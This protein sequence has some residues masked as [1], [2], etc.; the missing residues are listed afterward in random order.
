MI[1]KR[2]RP[3]KSLPR[4][5]VRRRRPA[6]G[7]QRPVVRR[8]SRR[9]VQPPRTGWRPSVRI[10]RGWLKPLG[11][12]AAVFAVLAAAVVTWQSPLFQV[13]HLE[14]R[15]NSRVATESIV[16]RAAL[17]GE[18]MFTADLATSQKAIYGLP[19]VHAV[20]I[21]RHWPNR[22]TIT[23]EERQAWG[24]WEQGG[25][26]YTIDRDGVVLGSLPAAE[27][28][29]VILSSEPG[30]RHQGDRVDYQ[31]V[32]AAAEIYERLPRQLGTT[33]TE[34]SFAKGTGVQVKTADGQ[35]AL[36]GD[37]SSIAYKLSVWAAMAQQA[38]ARGI[39]YTT[40]D[41]RFGNRP[42]LE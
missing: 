38:Q 15:G 17:L 37:S 41:L 5:I 35:A 40:V 22:L 8:S 25:V 42:V 33:V 34:V 31:A 12:L 26:R 30:S 16:E 21:D 24:T 11:A 10:S 7:E 2:R 14:V 39:N 3:P 6:V 13:A 9:G 23:V 19:L 29:P 32:E 4:T 27:G 18:N 20:R 1:V 28:A 36:F